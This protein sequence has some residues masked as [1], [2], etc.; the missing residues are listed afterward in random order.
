MG[1]MRRSERDSNCF[2]KNHKE[3][4]ELKKAVTELKNSLEEFS[5]SL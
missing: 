4:L 2:K 1:K 5:N 3:M